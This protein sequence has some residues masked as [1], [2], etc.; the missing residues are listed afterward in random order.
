MR[1]IKFRAWDK[2]KER[3]FRIGSIHFILGI[4][5]VNGV[6][7]TN[8]HN[9]YHFL[10]EPDFEVM[11]FTGLLDKNGVEIFTG[12][13][14]KMTSE[15]FAFDENVELEFIG[16]VRMT[17]RGV[18]LYKPKRI[19]TKDESYSHLSGYKQISGYRCEILGNIH[20]HKELLD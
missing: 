13:I 7:V 12:D 4:S 3:M 19:D 6:S 5:S 15:Y 11:Q 8:G 16:E 10:N 2:Q 18:L 9:D 17:S 20:E 14:L 1:E